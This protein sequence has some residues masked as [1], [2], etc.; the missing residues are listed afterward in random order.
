MLI[1][2]IQGS[3]EFGKTCLHNTCTLPNY[4]EHTWFK[5]FSTK[6]II[7]LLS[8]LRLAYK[9]G[10]SAHISTVRKGEMFPGRCIRHQSNWISYTFTKDG[11]APR[12]NNFLSMSLLGRR[13]KERVTMLFYLMFFMLLLS[14]LRWT[15]LYCWCQYVWYGLEC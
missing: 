11:G 12:K 6:T 1:L 13:S 7:R 4:P 9:S 3:P 14:M 15:V 10:L 8:Y 5:N 2:L